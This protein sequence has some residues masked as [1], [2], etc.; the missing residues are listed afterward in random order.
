MAASALRSDCCALQNKYLYGFG[1]SVLKRLCVHP[2]LLRSSGKSPL[3][4]GAGSSL[5]LCF[6]CGCGSS[7]SV[8]KI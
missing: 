7:G 6:L 4:F 3:A 2:A 1:L 5:L 8:S